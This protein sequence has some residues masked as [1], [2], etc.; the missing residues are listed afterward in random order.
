MSNRSNS[1]IQ[2]RFD[3][4]RVY[5]S[6]SLPTV[7]ISESDIYIYSN[8][9]TRL[10]SLAYEYYN[11]ASLWWIIARANNIGFGYAVEPGLQIRIP[12]NIGRFI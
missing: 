6:N 9:T 7:P 12:T 10:D 3:G 1:T 8:E 11:N 4:K 2:K 5:T